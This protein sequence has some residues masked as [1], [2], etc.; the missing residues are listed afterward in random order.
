MKYVIFNSGNGC[1]REMGEQLHGDLS[2][3]IL[4]ENES[5][6]A[7]D[8]T[9]ETDASHYMVNG[10]LTPRPDISFSTPPV[11]TEVYINYDMIGVVDDGVF[12]FSVDVPGFYRIEML[13]PFPYRP[14]IHKV[15]VD[16]I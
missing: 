5:I 6:A 9:F 11:G 14:L 8:W 10:V 15:M 16:E 12:D 1:I 2:E 4:R 13:P 7:I 3:N